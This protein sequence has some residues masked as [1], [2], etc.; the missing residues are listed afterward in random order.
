MS[1]LAPAIEATGAEIILE[2]PL[3]DVWL[4]RR[5]LTLLFKE[6]ICNAMEYRRAATPPRIHVAAQPLGGFVRFSVDDNGI[7]IESRYLDRIFGV[8]NR[9]HTREEHPGNG[10]GLAMVRK[11]VL[12]AGGEIGV[13]SAPGQGS[14]FFFTL[15][16]SQ[17]AVAL[18]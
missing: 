18:E 6:L 2:R 12:A 17:E 4:D 13:K 9:L 3:P 16:A 7:G 15:P 14:A 8:F 10:I 11:I 1:E 5:R